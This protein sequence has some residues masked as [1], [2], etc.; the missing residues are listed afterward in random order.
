MSFENYY[1]QELALLR[2]YAADFGREYPAIAPLLSGPGADPD[3]ER[4]LEGVAYLTANIQRRLDDAFPEMLH[5]LLNMV[6]PHFLRPIP[7]ATIMAF[8]PRPNLRQT[9]KIPAGTYVD[10]IP[11]DNT[12]CRF[13]TVRDLDVSPLTVTNAELQ[14]TSQ[15]GAVDGVRIKLD[16]ELNGVALSSWKTDRLPLYVTGADA[17]DLY[18]LLRRHLTGAELRTA[19][20]F[21]HQLQATDLR[22][23]GFDVGEGMSPLPKNVFPGFQLIQEYFQFPE[24]FMF[25]E[26]DLKGW[27]DRGNSTQFSLSFDCSLPSFPVPRV[28]NSRFLLNAVPAVNLFDHSADAILLDQTRHEV[29]IEP[30]GNPKSTYQVFSVDSV[31]GMRRG[32]SEKRPF[33][34]FSDRGGQDPSRPVFNTVVRTGLGNR[35][36]DV[37]L[38]VAYPEGEVIPEQEV[39][40]VALTCTNG[41]LPDALQQGDIRVPTSNT[42]ELV[43][44]RN[45][46]APTSSQPPPLEGDRLWHLLSH[47]TVNMLTLGDADSLKDMLRLYLFPEVRDKAREIAN[48]KRINGILDLQLEQKERLIGRS[49]M[50]GQRIII[51]TRA[52]HFAGPGDLYL[53]GCILDHFFASSSA[54]NHYTALVMHDQQR[55]ETIEWPARLGEKPLL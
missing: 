26:L 45:V 22:P 38:S 1:K 52:D 46:N 2:E 3:V 39:L 44:Y 18:L 30:S 24:K 19:D 36:T 5:T 32:S 11:V 53:F 6:A 7:A 48:L 12:P 29:P 54:I 31:Q 43:E 50:R 25:F 51:E 27:T 35:E 4:L 8:S 23:W 20:G 33:Q 47:M 17:A 37:L 9:L 21:I 41:N 10:S 42:P 16:L 34:S 28:D 40:D 13:R 49:I 15:G 55:G 14:E